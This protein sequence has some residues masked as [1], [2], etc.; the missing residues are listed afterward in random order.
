MS[1]L[2]NDDYIT[3]IWILHGM[4]AGCDLATNKKQCPQHKDNTVFTR[5]GGKSADISFV[6]M[7]IP[8]IVEKPTFSPS[9]TTR[10][11]HL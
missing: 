1:S 10:G 8:L 2:A 4:Y 9:L 3:I 7:L 11:N 6:Q 5:K